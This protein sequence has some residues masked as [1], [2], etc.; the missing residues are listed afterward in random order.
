MDDPYRTVLGHEQFAWLLGELDRSGAAWRLVANGVMIGQVYSE[1]MPEE[2]GN[3][4]SDLGVL[5]KKDHGSEPD[6]WDGYTAERDKLF[7]HLQRNV[8]GDTL[9]LSGACIRLGRSTYTAITRR[10][11]S[12]RSRSSSSR[13]A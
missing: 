3:P 4:L 1:F 12:I 8:A 7:E 6:Q 9:F 2:V 5:T 13:P 10:G 11:K